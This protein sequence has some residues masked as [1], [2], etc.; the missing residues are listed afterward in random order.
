MKKAYKELAKLHHPDRE[1]GNLERFQAISNAWKE[2][3]K[4]RLQRA[5]PG[6]PTTP[7]RADPAAPVRG[8]PE[9][10]IRDDAAV[11]FLHHWCL[12]VRG[13]RGGGAR[14]EA[15]RH[16]AS[17]RSPWLGPSGCYAANVEEEPYDALVDPPS[18]RP[19]NG[20]RGAGRGG[21]VR[22]RGD[23]RRRARRAVRAR[24][25]TGNGVLLDF[26]GYGRLYVRLPCGA[27]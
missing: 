24:E 20:R 19:R 5:R 18:T 15:R 25:S 7:R 22:R 2:Y 17:R 27:R 6:E 13:I 4:P 23:R 14:P 12:L 16:Q 26:D 9:Y 21:R 3:Q 1:T 11:R 8:F 10:W